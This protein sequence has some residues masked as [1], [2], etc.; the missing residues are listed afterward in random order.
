VTHIDGIE[1]QRAKWNTVAKK[2]L[3]LSERVAVRY[4]H[5]VIA[6]NEA[7]RIYVKDQYGIDAPLIAYG[8]DPSSDSLDGNLPFVLKFGDQ[9][10]F[11]TICRIEPENNVAAILEAFQRVP[12]Q[13]LVIVGNWNASRYG[14]DLRK[15]FESCQNI[16][17]LDPI[18]E[19]K[20]LK[21]LRSRAIGCIHG[22][23]AGGTNPT[24]VQAMFA[25]L[26][27]LAFDVVYNRYTTNGNADYWADP[28]E[29][30][31]LLERITP[32]RLRAN[33]IKMKEIAEQHYRWDRVAE[34]YEAVLF[35]HSH[36][37]IPSSLKRRRE[38]VCGKTSTP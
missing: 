8:G 18:Y 35:P 9:Q 15:R 3:R 26:P 10:Y 38:A 6:D 7:I 22:H 31:S 29:L 12:S 25:G 19:P 17:L 5:T 33:G 4:S 16:A 34:Q 1:W 14:R 13:R 36:H 24:L 37:P 20:T 27:V 23:S 30:A 2:F 11:L 32:T 21:A 28:S